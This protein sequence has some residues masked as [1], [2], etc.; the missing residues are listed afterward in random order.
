M[1]HEIL[2]SIHKGEIQLP[3]F[4]RD[5]VWDDDHIRSLI[6]SVSTSYPIGVIMV[7]EAGGDRAQFKTRLV[8]GVH[9][10]DS[11]VKPAQL[12]LDGQQRLTALYLAL[13]SRGPVPKHTEEDKTRRV[14]YLDIEKCLDPDSERLDAV[15]SLPLERILKSDF[16]RQIDL[17]VTTREKEYETGLFPLALMFDAA[18]FMEWKTGCERHFAYAREKLEI[19]ASFSTQVWLPFQRYRVPVIELLKATPRDAVCQVFERVNTGGVTLSV[20]ELVTAMFAAHDY[21]LRMDW[22]DRKERLHKYDQLRGLDATGF[23]TAVTLLSSYARKQL[24]AGAVSCKRKDILKLTL[25]EYKANADS[26]ERGMIA[27]MQL[28]T[29]EKIFDARTVPYRTQLIPLS[30]VCAFI[31]DRFDQDAIKQKLARWY[32]SGVFGELYGGSTETRFSMDIQDVIAWL[33]GGDEPRT[34]RDAN[35]TP[36]RLLTLQSRL[37]AAYKGLMAL[38]MQKDRSRDFFSGNSIDLHSYFDLAVDIHHIFPKFYCDKQGIERQKWNSVINKAPIS[39]QSN[40]S[41]GGLAP[42][43]YLDRIDSAGIVDKNDLDDILRSH[44]I[45]P[46][47]LRTDDFD[48]FIRDRGM[49]LLDLIEKAMGKAVTGRDADEVIAAFGLALSHDAE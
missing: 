29:R 25:D 24:N 43:A 49:R 31:G 2:E 27:A 28:L 44:L 41:I 35:F 15:I 20:F 5:W 48:G 4:Q 38:L 40:R 33:D 8:K 30:A 12:I 22:H 14:Y 32:W 47:L 17:D 7:I 16:G 45:D 9:L 26:V 42:S 36:V 10:P 11:E 6:A 46:E 19:L 21:Q 18:G 1:L 34:M 39:S 23:L 37:S 13:R 3:D